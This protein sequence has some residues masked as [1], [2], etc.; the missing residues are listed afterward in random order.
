[1]T[2][3]SDWV[4]AFSQLVVAGAAVL[5]AIPAYRGLTEWR[6]QLTGTRKVELAESVLASAY[7]IRD[8]IHWARTPGSYVGEGENRPAEHGEDADTKRT[9]DAY[10]VPMHRLKEEAEVF[11]DLLSRRYRFE[12]FFGPDATRPILEIMAVRDEIVISAGMLIRTYQG[13]SAK[14][15][16]SAEKWE[17]DI[18]RERDDTPDGLGVRLDR[19]IRQLEEICKPV[20]AGK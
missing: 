11:G 2:N 17:R 3:A 20:L 13:A 4:S 6:R 12:V 18:W 8:A 14:R 15:P 5:A 16:P 1:M 19:A 10:Y 7:S 9:R